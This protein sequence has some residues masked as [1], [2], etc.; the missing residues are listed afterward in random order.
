MDNTRS[1][2]NLSSL[3]KET[4]VQMDNT[5]GFVDSSPLYTGIELEVENNAQNG[6]MVTVKKVWWDLKP[7]NWIIHEEIKLQLFF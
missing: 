1:T 3:L 4:E 7:A 2:T 6:V 5:M